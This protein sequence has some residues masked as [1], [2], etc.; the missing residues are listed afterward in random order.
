MR[1]VPN[2]LPA[3]LLRARS[4]RRHVRHWCAVLT[5]EALLGVLAAMVLRVDY[6]NPARQARDSID[7]TIGQIN[8]VEGKLTA[9]KGE[10]QA[11]QQKLAVASQ[12]ASKPDWSIVLG[13][14]ARSGTHTV[15]LT[16]T[17][18][19]PPGA[20][21]DKGPVYYRLALVGV[22][23]TRTDVTRFVQALESCGIF[24]QVRIGQTQQVSNPLDADKPLVSFAIEAWLAEGG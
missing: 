7:A 9:A 19:M 10:L 23:P 21:T 16:S 6:D 5:L 2:L 24:A 4:R 22:S 11:V 15:E 14:V 18:L 8:V 20:A 3:A 1:P 17:Q 12:V 13:A